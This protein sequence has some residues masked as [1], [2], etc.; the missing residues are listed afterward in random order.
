MKRT[1]SKS[2][3]LKRT[4]S[5]DAGGHKIKRATSKLK[6]AQPP[7]CCFICS[8]AEPLENSS[9]SLAPGMQRPLC[10]CTCGAGHAHL[11]CLRQVAQTNEKVWRRCISCGEH[12]TDA[13]VRVHLARA[14]CDQ[15]ALKGKGWEDPERIR[16]ANHLTLALRLNSEF[17]EAERAGREVLAATRRIYGN[18]ADITLS[19]MARLS[20]VLADQGLTAK[21]LPLQL[22]ALAASQRRAR[23]R[24]RPAQAQQ[25]QAHQEQS[26]FPPVKLDLAASETEKRGRRKASQKV[27]G[28]GTAARNVAASLECL[29]R[30][31]VAVR[32]RAPIRR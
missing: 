11:E 19:A 15:T 16:S 12:W 17:E 14:W 22:E 24:Q 25:T 4:A 27:R 6:V 31:R 18:E 10:G 20:M 3:K 29:R 1:G 13:A 21:A 28:Q 30:R 7:P 26:R 23:A 5:K 2:E 32:G 8:S 9:L